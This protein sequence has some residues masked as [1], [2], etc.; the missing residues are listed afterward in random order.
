[1]DDS[2]KRITPAAVQSLATDT[3]FLRSFVAGL[4]DPI[5]LDNLDELTQTV[6]L[7]DSDNPDEYYDMSQRNKK[8]GKVDPLKGPMLSEKYEYSSSRLNLSANARSGRKKVRR[9]PRRAPPSRASPKSM[10]RLVEDSVLGDNI[11]SINSHSI[12]R[13]QH[14]LS[15]TFPLVYYP[16]SKGIRKGFGWARHETSQDINMASSAGVASPPRLKFGR[17]CR[18]IHG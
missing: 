13:V 12:S 2:V 1:M 16:Y 4:N 15:C 14:T 10:L 8:Y 17:V 7:M 5:L 18:Y 11:A 6:A 3:S 9:S